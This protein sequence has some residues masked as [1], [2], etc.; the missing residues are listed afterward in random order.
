M[1]T[2]GLRNVPWVRGMLDI[3]YE[4]LKSETMG[5]DPP[6]IDE[7]H[8]RKD[9]DR[10]CLTLQHE[11]NGR[12]RF[13]FL[14]AVLI[15]MI[16][17]RMQL[18]PALDLFFHMWESETDFLCRHLS[19]RW[20][21]SACDTVCDHPRQPEE[22]TIAIASSMMVNTIKLYETERRMLASTEETS[23]RID[24]ICERHFP[25]FD[26]LM[27]F[28]LKRGDVVKNLVQ[29][30]KQAHAIDGRF[31]A[32]LFFT[33]ADRVLNGDTVFERFRR[34]HIREESMW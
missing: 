2:E 24:A 18:Q 28:R 31:P 5:G 11:F 27:T 16:R 20:L 34:V 29:R 17:R 8:N 10:H 12:T 3:P 26:G 33:A 13:E 21:I 32:R 4:R 9:F 25:L 23:Q 6:P 15:V 1:H 14:H 30:I 7:P 22:A 19:L